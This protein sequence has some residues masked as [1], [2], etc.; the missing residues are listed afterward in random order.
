M[1]VVLPVAGYPSH[2]HQLVEEAAAWGNSVL[3]NPCMSM[4]AGVAV[5]EVH[6]PYCMG[7]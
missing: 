3:H 4:E 2:D 7:P 1:A 6:K 5:S